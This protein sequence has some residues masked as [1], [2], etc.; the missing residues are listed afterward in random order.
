MT[1]SLTAGAAVAVLALG[2]CSGPVADEPDP[3][4]TPA[5][6]T[7]SEPTTMSSAAFTNPV[8]DRDFPDPAVIRAHGSW[9]AF[10]T[11]SALGH[12]PALRSSDLV[13]W[14]PVGDAMPVLAP[15]VTAGRTWAPEVAV[16]AADR[17]VVYY[18]ALSTR[19][20]RQ[21]IGRAVASSPAGPFVDESETP[22]ICQADEGGSI[23]ASP[24][25]DTDGTRYLLWKNDGNAVGVDTWIYAQR[26][27]PDGLELAG[28]PARLM[29][30]D[31]AWEGHL[32][33]APFLWLRDGTYYLFYSAN[34][35]ASASYA[36]GY[37]VCDGPLGPC[38]KP[39]DEPILTTSDDA[40]GPG[41]CMLVEKDGRTWMVYH[42]WPPDAVGSAVPGR[43][44]WMS[45]LTWDGTRPVVEGPH[46]EVATSP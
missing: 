40:A 2:G 6:D 16:H 18:T 1:R 21:C 41:H 23:D 7:T 11:N 3:E 31:Q 17:Y 38:T 37:A 33:E 39:S 22:L 4:A 46:A 13:Q 28:E 8:Y 14:E 19:S 34:D 44:M 15:W 43:T 25:T 45:E 9:F 10:A 12:M 35:Y 5:A 42:A 26:L 20:G 32:V 36:V 30:Q 29:R 24:F 27:T